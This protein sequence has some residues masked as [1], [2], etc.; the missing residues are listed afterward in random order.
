MDIKQILSQSPK[1][2]YSSLSNLSIPVSVKRDISYE[3]FIRFPNVENSYN[4]ETFQNLT[5]AHRIILDLDDPEY[6]MSICEYLQEFRDLIPLN[7]MQNVSPEDLQ[8]LQILTSSFDADVIISC[9]NYCATKNLDNNFVY[10]LENMKNILNGKMPDNIASFALSVIQMNMFEDDNK[11]SWILNKFGEH[12]IN[13]YTQNYIFYNPLLFLI[14]CI[15]Y[16]NPHTNVYFDAMVNS[17]I[18][19]NTLLSQNGVIVSKYSN[20]LKMYFAS[21]FQS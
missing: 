6:I 16:N 2:I 17:G 12:C 10:L 15:H 5:L 21:I 14:K 18:N 20:L 1:N 19:I 9:V 4:N 3:I 11:N 8:N 7:P 13:S